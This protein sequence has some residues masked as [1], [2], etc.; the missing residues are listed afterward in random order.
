MQHEAYVCILRRLGH[1]LGLGGLLSITGLVM[2]GHKAGGTKRMERLPVTMVVAHVDSNGL[3]HDAINVRYL[4]KVH[5]PLNVHC[6]ISVW[7]LIA[8][9]QNLLLLVKFRCVLLL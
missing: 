3:F 8:S 2:I 6:L 1:H 4:I 9:L 7:P 5:C